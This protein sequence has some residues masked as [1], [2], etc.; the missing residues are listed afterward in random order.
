MK[1]ILAL[2][3]FILFSLSSVAATDIITSSVTGTWTL[4]GSPY[5]IHCNIGTNGTLNIE[6]GVEVIFMGAYTFYVGRINAIG[7]PSQHIVFRANDTTGWSDISIAGGGWNGI[8]VI[9]SNKLVHASI[10][11]SYFHFLAVF[12]F[13]AFLRNVI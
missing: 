3:I 13:N 9:T 5:K 11:E 12:R 10:C 1:K 2:S 4:G 8:N 6:P 7:T